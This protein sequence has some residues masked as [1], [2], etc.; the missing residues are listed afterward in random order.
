MWHPRMH[1][2]P[3]P[4]LPPRCLGKMALLPSPRSGRPPPPLPA[5]GKPGPGVCCC[6]PGACPGTPP[7]GKVVYCT[8]GLKMTLQIA[9]PSNHKS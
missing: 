5:A 9:A 4:T 1:D 8:F 7:S 2:P 6:S 3:Y